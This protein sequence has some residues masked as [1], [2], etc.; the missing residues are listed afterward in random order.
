MAAWST[1]YFWK[2]YRRRGRSGGRGYNRHKIS[3]P[4]PVLVDACIRGWSRALL[5]N[6]QHPTAHRIHTHRLAT[7]DTRILLSQT[8]HK[9]NLRKI[10]HL[11]LDSHFLHFLTSITSESAIKLT[12][13]PPVPIKYQQP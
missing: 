7:T 1:F 11:L 5:G 8:C 9:T 2:A 13:M 3:S 10:P 12:T 6:I 4:S